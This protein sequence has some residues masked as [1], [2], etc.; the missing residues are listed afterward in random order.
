M[1]A[2]YESQIPGST[3]TDTLI[4]A[5]VKDTRGETLTHAETLAHIHTNARD[6]QTHNCYRVL[7]RKDR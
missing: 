4:H 6:T 2:L 5:H 7:S 3:D 1:Q